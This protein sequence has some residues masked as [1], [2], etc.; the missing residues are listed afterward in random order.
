VSTLKKK[1]LPINMEVRFIEFKKL[2]ELYC[3]I[4][5]IP[6]NQDAV[7]HILDTAENI[8]QVVLTLPPNASQISR[9]IYKRVKM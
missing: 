8:K 5:G 1:K 3:Q 4:A 9:E 2:Q 7:R 6:Y